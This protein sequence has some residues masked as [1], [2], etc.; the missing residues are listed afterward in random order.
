LTSTWQRPALALIG[1]LVATACGGA[2]PSTSGSTVIQT[3]SFR[4]A[5]EG[6][7]GNI[8]QISLQR[9]SDLLKDQSGG[10][11]TLSVYPGGQLM[12]DQEA[13]RAVSSSA[14]EVDA[15]IPTWVAQLAPD[16][17]VL[18]M[19]YAFPPG[20][21][22]VL[23]SPLLKAIN[24]ELA[25]KNVVGLTMWSAGSLVFA[26]RKHPIL[27]PSDFKGL[28]LRISGGAA[29]ATAINALGANTVTLPAP[30]L[31]TAVQTGAIDGLEAAEQYWATNFP[32]TLKYA[33]VTDMFW[34]GFGLWVSKKWW[35]GLNAATR[36]LMT[37][38]LE[39][40]STEATTKIVENTKIAAAKAVAKGAQIHELTADESAQFKAIL[41]PIR[42]QILAKYP[43]AIQASV[44][45]V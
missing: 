44:S 16:I 8:A 38:T 25:P 15:S 32:D 45:K 42:Q 1:I 19:P 3:I 39:Q 35:N 31:A 41:G 30:E 12:T 13:M 43:P 27:V 10:K 37:K 26:N 2:A 11:I 21:N 5:T 4:G 33:T 29:T 34:T 7:V 17:S 24:E 22:A 23:N 9:W 20:T 36:D 14:L 18:D 6:P 28:K 40:V